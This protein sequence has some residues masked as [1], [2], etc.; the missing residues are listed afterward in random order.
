MNNKFIV[1]L[2]IL[3]S[4]SSVLFGQT[5]GSITSDHIEKIKQLYENDEKAKVITNALSN[6]DIQKLALIRNNVGKIDHYFKYKVDVKG[7]TDQKSSGRCWMFTA[8]NILR[9]KVI[10]NIKLSSFE[11][12]ENYLYFWDIFEKSNLFLEATIKYGDKPMD[13]KYVEWL[14]KS[15]VNDGGVWNS[16]SNLAIKYGLVPKEIMPETNSSSNTRWMIRLIKRKL[17]EDALE[18][19]QMAQKSSDYKKLEVRKIEMLSEIYKMLVFNLGEPPS[20]FT[21]RYKDKNDSI[22]VAKTFTPLSFMQEILPE[23]NLDDYVLLMNDPTR[24]YYKLYEIEYDRNVLEGKNWIYINLPSDEIKVFALES[25]KNNE[26]MY[27]SC[28]VGKQL[29]KNEGLLSIDNYD[30]EAIYGIKFGMNKKDR[31]LSRESGSSHGMALVAVDVDENENPIK[32]QFENSWGAKS[33]HNG[34]L[35][36]T[37]KWFD[38]YMFRIVVL[39]KFVDAKTLK[40]L[41]QKP[42]VLPPWDP[43]FSMDE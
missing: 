27:A 35:T 41:D 29:N 19:R 33:G 7:I 13:N 31:I 36:F 24:E 4:I 43:M 38:E 26:A 20:E 3:V 9:P 15:P 23:V 42:I 37:D 21:W 25:I 22:S 6:N 2:I 16:F 1:V 40:I 32:W 18:L 14:F 8:L 11:F 28:D 10:D 5:K 30:Y 34:Y 39:K 12:S 17:R